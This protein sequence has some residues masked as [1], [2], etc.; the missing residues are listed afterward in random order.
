MADLATGA[1]LDRAMLKLAWLSSLP[2][3]LLDYSAGEVGLNHSQSVSQLSKL[4]VSPPKAST[5]HNSPLC[6][7]LQEQTPANIA[8]TSE[9]V[10]TILL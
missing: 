5:L 6:L 4:L 10:R 2:Q 3:V 9:K 1:L 8:A 7:L